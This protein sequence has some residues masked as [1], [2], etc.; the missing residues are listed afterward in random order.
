MLLRYAGK[1]GVAQHARDNYFACVYNQ[2]PPLNWDAKKNGVRQKN[3]KS[4]EKTSKY[5]GN[6]ELPSSSMT[7]SLSAA[8]RFAS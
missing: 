7:V 1:R 5:D 3:M 8:W 2:D 6:L 4:T